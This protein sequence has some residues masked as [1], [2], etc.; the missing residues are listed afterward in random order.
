[1]GE[2]HLD[3][4]TLVLFNGN[5]D[6]SYQALDLTGQQ[7]DAAGYFVV[8]SAA[9]P[10]VDVVLANGLIQNGP[11]AVALYAASPNI[12]PI[13]TPVTTSNL[14]DAVVYGA[15]ADDGLLKL[16][17]GGQ[18]MVYEG[19]TGS[20]DTDSLQRC[21][22]GTGGAR[23]TDTVGIGP[24]TPGATN[25]CSLADTAPLLLA[26][27][28]GNDATGVSLSSTIALSFSEAVELS[29]TAVAVECDQSGKHTLLPTGGP[30]SFVM[31]PVGSF[32]AAETCQ[33]TV[34]AGGVADVDTIDP[35]DT[36]A[37]DIIWSFE[38]AAQSVTAVLINEFDVD[39]P[40][41]DTAEFIEL[42]DGGWGNQSLDGLVVVLFNGGTST[43]YRTIDLSGKQTDSEGY[44]VLGGSDIS[45]SD[46]AL[47]NS[48]LQNGPDAIAVYAASPA[49]FP[50]GSA[51]S[52]NGLVDAVV[53]GT[54]DPDAPGL[55]ALLLPGQ[56]Q[57]NESS[58][59]NS[60]DDANQ[61]CPNGAGVARTTADFSQASPT[62][63]AVNSCA[64]NDAA[65]S[66]IAFVPSDGSLDVDPAATL[67]IT[68]S[69][70]VVPDPDWLQL[71]CTNSGIRS[72]TI[73][74]GPNTFTATP[75]DPLVPGDACE[76]RV[77]A[78]RIHDA[79]AVDPPDTMASDVVW[80]F[81]VQ[82]DEC[83]RQITPIAAIQG[84]GSAS[85]LLGSIVTT[86]GVLT[87][88]FRDGLGGIFLQSP[89]DQSDGNPATS[90]GLFVELGD[91]LEPLDIGD[92]LQ[93]TG[94]V[95]EIDQRT[96]L[97]D[98]TIAAGC[99]LNG[100]V[101][102]TP[103]PFPPYT[104]PVWESLEGMLVTSTQA[105]TII[106]NHRFFGHSE[107]VVKIGPRSDYP[108]EQQLPGPAAQAALETA[109]KGYLLLDDGRIDE[110]TPESDM[111]PVRAGDIV[112]GVTGIIDGIH[113]WPRIHTT[114]PP[115]RSVANPRP[116]APTPQPDTLRIAVVDLGR[117]PAN[118][119]S[120]IEFGRRQ[121]KRVALLLALRADI[122]SLTGL[123]IDGA[124]SGSAAHDLLQALNAANDGP[125]YAL[126]A[127]PVSSAAGSDS[128][129]IALYRPDRVDLISPPTQP[130]LSPTGFAVPPLLLTVRDRATDDPFT[131]MLVHLAPRDCPADAP[132]AD[133]R[134]AQACRSA[135]RTQAALSLGS[136]LASQPYAARTL[137]LGTWNAYRFEDPLQAITGLGFSDLT[138]A[139]AY[140]T[141]DAGQ[142]AAPHRV[143][144][145]STVA[146]QVAQITVWHAN[147]DESAEYDD[148]LS[149]PPAL[150]AAD[151]Y[152]AAAADPVLID[153]RLGQLQTAFS[154]TR[155][156]FH[157]P[158]CPGTKHHHRSR[159]A[160]LYL[161]LR[162]RQPAQHRARPPPHLRPHRH[163]PDHPYGRQ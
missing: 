104:P 47:P 113:G 7:T 150:Y 72:L 2:P 78:D 34:L 108:T 40:G 69:E 62:P 133:R 96:T 153:L 18:S 125:P 155:C 157:R 23:N 25:G 37:A 156:R 102:L 20:A 161:G 6:T 70:A 11:D 110:L 17:N 79:D 117:L 94:L 32:L 151:P 149:N 9:V 106:D 13:N 51:I 35:P 29:T 131:L 3:G 160:A 92:T 26:F 45:N 114:L 105:A 95:A 144:A 10:G 61:R 134:D 115:T 163:L 68:F 89:D 14:V 100:S 97:S 126:A 44:L 53:Y 145:G 67:A 99:G 119:P 80:T 146:T 43:S 91:I 76:A 56:P 159:P 39:T 81:T 49:S 77:L 41:I 63:G 109:L 118:N 24:P 158:N 36:M 42:Y 128:Q 88:D 122:L 31:T 152:R 86:V 27:T 22:N 50:N 120:L 4:L 66:V 84:S 112:S 85:P 58:R 16:L 15:A 111:E 162:R 138:P 124:Q 48:T 140:T 148:R 123:E 28:P 30:T 55:L 127:A 33:V 54:N 116:P 87:A 93:V 143:V 5:G 21:P 132:D 46:I 57:V 64:P 75:D 130:P 74:G 83:G 147:A 139:G 136:W 65:P 135:A 107:L 8:G 101:S 154:A 82:Q 103:L 129:S 71:T 141:I 12:F 121:D 142:P 52:L 90:E 73:L 1:M 38:T 59:G 19:A 137:L 98:V 60:A